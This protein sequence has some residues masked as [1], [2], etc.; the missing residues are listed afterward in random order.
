MCSIMGYPG[1]VTT[2]VPPGW[3]T[4]VQPPGSPDFERSAATWLLDVVPSDYLLHGVLKRHPIALASLARHHLNACVEGAR[5]GYRTARSEL[6]PHLPPGAVEAVLAAYR[7]EGSRLA[8]AARAA[9]LVE[10]ALH[11]EVFVRQMGGRARPSSPGRASG[12][13]SRTADRPGAASRVRSRDRPAGSGVAIAQQRVSRQ[14]LPQQA[15]RQILAPHGRRQILPRRGHNSRV[16][17]RRR[18]EQQLG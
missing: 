4:G 8:A 16:L 7:S 15:R 14:I 2:F 3:P 1:L 11:G 6:G 9:D 13:T 10:R 17:A 5:S 12:P 18:S